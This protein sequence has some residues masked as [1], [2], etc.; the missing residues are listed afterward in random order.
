[1]R[2][3]REAPLYSIW[4][5]SGNVI[6]L[7]ILRAL[8]REPDAGRAVLDELR[9]A[10][11]SHRALKEYLEEL[12]KDLSGQGNTQRDANESQARR[13]AER[14]ALALQASL[15]I[16]HASPEAAHAFVASRLEDDHGSNYGTLSS[17]VD[18][19]SLVRRIGP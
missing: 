5:G 8:K 15:M 17:K 7:D 3:Y 13:L 6:A 9:Q 11:R 2:L 12:E 14:L 18:V 4:E 19:S 1:P 16:R 10:A